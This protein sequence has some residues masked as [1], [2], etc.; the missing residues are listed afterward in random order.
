LSFW[1]RG[2][3]GQRKKEKERVAESTEISLIFCFF[4]FLFNFVLLGKRGKR[5][6]QRKRE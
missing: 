5:D 3:E 4:S 6:R 2:K 1:V